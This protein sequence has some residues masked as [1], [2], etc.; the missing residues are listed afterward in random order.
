M[1]KYILAL[2]FIVVIGCVNAPN[3]DYHV[4]FNDEACIK[5]FKGYRYL[6]CKNMSVTINNKTII[7]PQD[8]QTDLASIP[9]WLWP[10]IA[11]TN[12][13][14]IAPSILHD[15]LYSCIGYTRKEADDIFYHALIESDVSSMRAYEMYLAVRLFGG[16]HYDCG[17]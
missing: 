10:I 7:V 2:L 1:V 9:R 8:Y 14:F 11:P 17:L 6:T 12:S 3:Y 4:R 15:Y 16:S 5:P 13:S